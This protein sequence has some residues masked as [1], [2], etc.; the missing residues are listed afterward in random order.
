MDTV[1]EGRPKRH[2]KLKMPG[3]FTILFILTIV[4]VIATWFVPA[5]SYSKLSYNE[6]TSQLEI[7]KNQTGRLKKY[8]RH[9]RS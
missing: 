3:A 6:P 1:A 8:Q 5:G 4:A 2:F 9:K 7:K